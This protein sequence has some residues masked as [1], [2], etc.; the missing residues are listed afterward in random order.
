MGI[1]LIVDNTRI[2]FKKEL[3]LKKLP[4]KIE[5]DKFYKFEISGYVVFP[6]GKAIHLFE[7]G[8]S[9]PVASIEITEQTNFLLGG[10]TNTKGEYYIR[11]LNS[12]Y[13]K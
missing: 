1:E 8:A 5:R 10:M 13:S 4:E 12:R 9:N 2:E 11:V 7:E 6:I 3:R